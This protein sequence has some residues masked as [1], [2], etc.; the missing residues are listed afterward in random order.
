M[1]FLQFLTN[2]AF[3]AFELGTEIIVCTIR[4]SICNNDDLLGISDTIMYHNIHAYR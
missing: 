2:W 1:S 4:Y 3:V